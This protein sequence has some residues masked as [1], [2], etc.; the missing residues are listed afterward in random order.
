MKLFIK[1]LMISTLLSQNFFALASDENPDNTVKDDNP[2]IFENDK[3]EEKPYC[4]PTKGKEYSGEGCI[5]IR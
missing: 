4:E 5:D 3:K 1:I 2:I